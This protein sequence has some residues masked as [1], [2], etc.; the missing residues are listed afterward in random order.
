MPRRSKKKEISIELLGPMKL[1]DGRRRITRSVGPEGIL[2]VRELLLAAGF[3]EDEAGYLIVARN[4]TALS[5]EEILNPGDMVT[6]FL[7]VGGG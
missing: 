6:V 3:S 5:P 4:N 2:T 1:P 7:P